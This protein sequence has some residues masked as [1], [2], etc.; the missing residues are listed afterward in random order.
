MENLIEG[1]SNQKSS[2]YKQIK[3][4]FIN[5]WNSISFFI[6]L[7]FIWIKHKN[8]MRTPKYDCAY[9]IFTFNF[10]KKH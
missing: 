5:E 1:G 10:T 3:N 4:I 9:S 8:Y 6:Y 7:L 2:E